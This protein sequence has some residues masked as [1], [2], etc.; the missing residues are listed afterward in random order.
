[1]INDVISDAS[2]LSSYFHKSGEWTFKLKQAAAR[3][4][5]SKSLSET[6]LLSRWLMYDRIHLIAFVAN[7][8]QL[9]KT[10]QKTFETDIISLLDL[11]P[12]KQQLIDKLENLLNVPMM[13]KLFLSQVDEGNLH[14]YSHE[15]TKGNARTV[16]S[17][18]NFF[19]YQIV[20]SIIKSLID[21]LDE[22]LDYDVDL[23]VALQPLASIKSTRRSLKL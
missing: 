8:L 18:N 15:L 19:D 10:Y 9:L 11:P 17:S 14:F 6:G 3:A 2:S 16:R 22:R 7:I 1:M 23:Q 5:L 20:D 4:K 13:E 12:K 21:L